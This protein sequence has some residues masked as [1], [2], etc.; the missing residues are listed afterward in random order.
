MLADSWL[1]LACQE[2]KALVLAYRT[3]AIY[4]LKQKKNQHSSLKSSALRPG[5]GLSGSRTLPAPRAGSNRENRNAIGGIHLQ[6]KASGW[7]CGH[8]GDV[9]QRNCRSERG[10]PA[11]SRSQLLDL[12][13][14][15]YQ[16]V[17][18][19]SLERCAV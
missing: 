14:I 13:W 9:G 11:R 5:P 2:N 17:P 18:V 8:I 19:R 15:C 10:W 1:I 6:R 16:Q 4:L 12:P 7:V 3:A